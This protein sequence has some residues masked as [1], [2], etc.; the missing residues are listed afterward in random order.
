MHLFQGHTEVF[1]ELVTVETR[2]FEEN[3]SW[4]RRL[5]SFKKIIKETRVDVLDDI[6]HGDREKSNKLKKQLRTVVGNIT[7]TNKKIAGLED[8]SRLYEWQEKN[9]NHFRKKLATLQQQADGIRKELRTHAASENGGMP[10]QILCGIDFFEEQYDMVMADTVHLPVGPMNFAWIRFLETRGGGKF[11]HKRTGTEMTNGKG[12]KCLQNFKKVTS[13]ML[14][15]WGPGT[16]EYV[17]L[18]ERVGR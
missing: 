11:D 1:L 4:Q 3:C 12:M 10:H 15:M 8:Q 5:A 2:A 18:S 14:G 7:R 6:P 13:A 9:L 16:R 17:W